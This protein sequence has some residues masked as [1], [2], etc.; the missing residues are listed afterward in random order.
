[1]AA[2]RSGGTASMLP[3]WRSCTPLR[4]SSGVSRSITSARMRSSPCTSAVGRLQFSVENAYRV[5]YSTPCSTAASTILRMFSV[6]A[7]CPASRGSPRCLAQ[8]PLP[9]MIM[10][11]CRGTGVIRGRGSGIGLD[12]H[13][14]GFFSLAH[15]LGIAD[16]AVNQGLDFL[17]GPL[18]LILGDHLF[19]FQLFQVVH[20]MAPDVAD[21][22]PAIL[23][24]ALDQLDELAA[25]LLGQ[26]RDDNTDELAVIRGVEPELRF[27]DGFLDRPDHV[28]F[29]GLDL[30]QAGLRGG[31][32]RHLVQGGRRAIILDHDPLDEGGGGPAR[33]DRQQLAA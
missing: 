28:L 22:D 13:H 17:A 15:M 14:F 21:G 29:P 19:V 23:H 32:R 4:S 33:A 9:S 2:A 16:V 18:M 31:D 6:P 24:M 3:R 27:L 10:A 8:R 11:T 7:R 25:A 12:L 20:R 30:Q 26:R 5:R 1:M